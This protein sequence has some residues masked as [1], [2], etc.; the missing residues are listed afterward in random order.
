MDAYIRLKNTFSKNFKF[1]QRK[2]PRGEKSLDLL[3]WEMRDHS[4]RVDE[5]AMPGREQLQEEVSPIP[6]KKLVKK[7]T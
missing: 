1:G 4:A 3:R 2:D 5:F 6:G 7:R